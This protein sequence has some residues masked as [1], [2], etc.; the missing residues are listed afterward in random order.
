MSIPLSL[1][2]MRP[3]DLLCLPQDRRLHSDYSCECVHKQS[4]SGCDLAL[5]Q[6]S[7]SHCALLYPECSSHCALFS[8]ILVRV[9]SLNEPALALLAVATVDGRRRIDAAGAAAAAFSADSC[10]STNCTSAGGG[11]ILHF[12]D[13]VVRVVLCDD[14]AQ[15][16]CYAIS[17]VCMFQWFC[18]YHCY[19]WHYRW[20]TWKNLSHMTVLSVMTIQWR[21]KSND[22][23]PEVQTRRLKSKRKER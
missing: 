22:L 21:T 16:V 2:E 15:G 10:R 19:V 23:F 3:S 5:Y 13:G 6:T 17:D 18:N 11:D 14:M 4:S 9:C 7:S 20:H 1:M 12:K 8:H